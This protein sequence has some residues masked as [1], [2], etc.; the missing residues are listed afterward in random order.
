MPQLNVHHQHCTR[1]STGTENLCHQRGGGHYECRCFAKFTVETTLCLRTTVDHML[2]TELQI[3]GTYAF[4]RWQIFSR[5][6]MHAAS[7]A[8]RYQ[9]LIDC[10]GCHTN[11]SSPVVIHVHPSLTPSI[12]LSAKTPLNIDLFTFLSDIHVS[13]AGGHQQPHLHRFKF[14][15]ERPTFKKNISS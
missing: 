2:P 6:P 9:R 1:S 12:S 3:A 7:A 15:S 4:R 14:Y 13:E 10:H 8:D 5:L 11:R